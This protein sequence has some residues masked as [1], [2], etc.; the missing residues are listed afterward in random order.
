[1]AIRASVLDCASPLALWS[2]QSND[3]P[4][5]MKRY[6]FYRNALKLIEKIRVKAFYQR[7]STLQPPFALPV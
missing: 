7:L 3:T 6:V 5:R 1:M 2:G 4:V